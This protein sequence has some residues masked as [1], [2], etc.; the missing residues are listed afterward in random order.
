MLLKKQS[1]K[2]LCPIHLQMYY[3]YVKPKYNDKISNSE[4]IPTKYKGFRKDRNRD[5]GG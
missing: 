2:A 5:G 3:F 1:L 4:F